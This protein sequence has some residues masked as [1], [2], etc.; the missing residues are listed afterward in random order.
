M[1]Y[2]QQLQ[3]QMGRAL[4]AVHRAAG[5]RVDYTIV[6]DTTADHMSTTLLA[7]IYIQPAPRAKAKEVLGGRFREVK[8]GAAALS[9]FL[10]GREALK[11]GGVYFDPTLHDS[12][13]ETGAAA[14]RLYV[15]EISET[16]RP[17]P[18]WFLT[19]STVFRGGARG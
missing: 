7:G 13:V 18:G 2:L 15:V 16:A 5:F 17:A 19:A 6:T 12:F 9:V 14:P 8:T 10:I 11:S 1:G 3:R 4:K